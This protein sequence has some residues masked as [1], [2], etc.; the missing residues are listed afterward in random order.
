MTEHR[1][2]IAALLR[3]ARGDYRLYAPGML[4]R[5]SRFLRDDT[6]TLLGFEQIPDLDLLLPHEGVGPSA[7]VEPDCLIRNIDQGAAWEFFARDPGLVERLLAK[8][9]PFGATSLR[10]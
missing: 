5:I 4:R 3:A 9:R 1:E 2:A 8:W 10:P 6:S 7:T